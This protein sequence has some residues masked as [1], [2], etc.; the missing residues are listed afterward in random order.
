MFGATLTHF[1]SLP[2]LGC[3][4]NS[5]PDQFPTLGKSPKKKIKKNFISSTVN[6]K[7]S[8]SPQRNPDDVFPP[9]VCRCFLK[10]C[11]CCV[12]PSG[13]CL[14]PPKEFDPNAHISSI[15]SH[16]HSLSYSSSYSSIPRPS[17]PSSPFFLQIRLLHTSFPPIL[18]CL[19]RLIYPE[20]DLTEFKITFKPFICRPLFS[21]P[22][23]GLLSH[24]LKQLRH[25]L[26]T[27]CHHSLRMV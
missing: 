3:R 11:L 16:S 25:S 9:Q 15:S 5:Q 10:S 7:K 20:L 17:R 22:P 23:R 14:L 8:R 1:P 12:K 6:P 19:A 4:Q 18:R 21:Q 27:T 26:L 13:A 24:I 2:F